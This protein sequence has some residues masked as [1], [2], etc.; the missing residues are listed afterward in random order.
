MGSPIEINIDNSIGTITLNRPE[1]L[2]AINFEMWGD[3]KTAAEYLSTQENVRVVILKGAGNKAFSSGA[4]IKDF[5]A[6]RSSSSLAREYAMSF[7]GALD[8]IEQMPKPTIS[9]I[10]GICIGGGCELSMATDLRIASTSSVFAVPVAK[11]G[12]L[13]GYNEMRRLVQ[14][15]GRGHASNLLLTARKIDGYE[16]LKIGLIT[17]LIDSSNLVDFT[18]QLAADIATYAPLTQSGHKK[19]MQTVLNDP[20]LSAMS[21]E[22][23]SL[24][25]S[26]FDTFDGM[27]GYRAFVEKRPPKFKGK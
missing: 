1:Q 20:S 3:L 27:E 2:N 18:Y 7:E 26:V 6:H 14:L 19:I 4:D 9:M 23:A 12:V 8:A 5:P 22:Q 17:D 24:P 15:V 21:E 10:N 13:V 16:A 11:I 25:L